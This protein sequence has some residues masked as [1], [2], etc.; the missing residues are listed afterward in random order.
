MT[1]ILVT[2]GTG[3][4]GSR[5][6]LRCRDAGEQVLVLAPCRTPPERRRADELRASGIDVAEVSVT[7]RDAVRAA[8]RGTDTVY[9]LAAAQHEANVPDS[10]FHEIN[11]EGTRN[12][13][14]ASLDAGVERVVHGSTIGVYGIGRNGPVTDDSPLAPDNI[15]GITKLAGERVALE[16]STRLPLAIVRISETYGPSD[17]RLLKL[18]RGLARGRFA[19]IGRGENLHHPIYVDDLVEGLRRAAASADI[20]RAPMV[21]AGPNAVTTREMVEAISMAVE[22]PAPRLRIPLGPLM[23]AATVSERT[24]RPLG[25]QPLLH[26]RRMNFFVKSFSFTCAAAR[27]AIAFDPKISF[28]DGAARVAAWYRQ[29]GL[30]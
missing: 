12:V 28:G 10:Y 7:D 26:P 4:I 24:L 14:E 17:W 1:R 9:H 30:I 29:Q 15:Y 21:L 2:G 8:V 19:M 20:A 11:V 25:I 5:L 18:F 16:Y 22:R 13:L 6:A 23:L 27:R 3:F